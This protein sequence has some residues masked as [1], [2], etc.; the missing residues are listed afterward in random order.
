MDPEKIQLA[1]TLEWEALAC[2]IA[3]TDFT[4]LPFEVKAPYSY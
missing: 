3:M 1:L 4:Y 2:N